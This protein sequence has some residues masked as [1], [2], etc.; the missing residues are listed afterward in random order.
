MAGAFAFLGAHSPDICEYQ[1]SLG[2]KIFPVIIVLG[3]D[4]WDSWSVLLKSVPRKGGYHPTTSKHIRLTRWHYWPPP[5]YLLC[6][7]INIGKAGMIS[8]RRESIVPDD[9][10][11]LRMSFPLN[12]RMH[13]HRQ[14]KRMD[15]RY[16]LSDNKNPGFV[17]LATNTREKVR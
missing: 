9:P 8:N 2:N 10:I 3:N 16:S 15:H 4:M 14:V 1:R 5:K 13:H 7:R 6:H 11:N 12:L 17:R